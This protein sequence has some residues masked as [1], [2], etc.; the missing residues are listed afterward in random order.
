M[1]RVVFD[2]YIECFT[3]AGDWEALVYVDQTFIPIAVLLADF[4]LLGLHILQAVGKPW[5]L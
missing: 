5:I 3:L 2:I 4:L 1:N